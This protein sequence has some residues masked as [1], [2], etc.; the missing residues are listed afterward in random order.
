MQLI[1]RIK[2]SL[3][4]FFV[5]TSQL[6]VAQN[7]CPAIPTN[8][9]WDTNCFIP[10]NFPDPKATDR[11]NG[12]LYL[13]EAT[14]ANKYGQA[15][16][17][18]VI[19]NNRAHWA[20]GIAHAW[21]YSRNINKNPAHPK[22]S[23]WMATALQ[24]SEWRCDQNADWGGGNV[25][26]P[27]GTTW[28]DIWVDGCFQIEG[29]NDGSAYGALIQYYPLRFRAGEHPNLVGNNNFVSSTLVKAYY[30]IFTERIAEYRWG[31]DYIAS[32]ENTCDPFAFEKASASSYNGGIYAFNGG[33]AWFNRSADG[34][35]RW[36]GLPATTAGY[37][38]QIGDIMAV[39]EGGWFNFNGYGITTFNAG[40][41][42]FDGYYNEAITWL[43]VVNYMDDIDDL[44]FDVNFATDVTPNAQAAFVK[45]AG[46][47]ANTINFQDI[48]PVIDAVILSLPREDAMAPALSN[49]GS[50]QGPNGV[51]CSG[52]LVPFS[53]I[54][55]QGLTT[56][57]EGLSLDLF[58]VIDGGGG[59]NPTYRWREGSPSGATIGTEATLTIS[60]T[61]G[62]YTYY[63]EVCN[64]N[65]CYPAC[66]ELEVV[67]E[68]CGGCGMTVSGVPTNTP[69][70]GM[71]NGSIDL[72]INGNASNNYQINYDGQTS[73][74]PISGNT[75]TA[76][77]TA[78][79]TGFADG[80]YN[81]EIVDLTDPTCRAFTNVTVG[82]DT[83]INEYI[84]ASI[85]GQSSSPTCLADLQGE[86]VELP[87]PC[88]FRVEVSP[89]IYGWP[90]PTDTTADNNGW[91]A[92]INAIIDP[93]SAGAQSIS[94][95][96]DRSLPAE[97]FFTM[98]TG[99]HFDF[100]TQAT[101]TPGATQNSNYRFRVYDETNDLVFAGY[102]DAG[103]ATA[104]T[105]Y[106]LGSYEVTCPYNPSDYTYS[107][108]PNLNNIVNTAL[109]TTGETSVSNNTDKTFTVTASNNSNPTCILTDTVTVPQDPSCVSN[110]TPPTSITLTPT[111]ATV[112]EG[113]DQ[114]FSTSVTGTASLDEY[115]YTWY[116]QSNN[117]IA[118]KIGLTNSD[119]NFDRLDLTSVTL[120]QDGTYTLRVEDGNSSDGSCYLE[121]TFNLTVNTQ[122]TPSLVIEAD[123]T[124]I[125]ENGTIDFSIT[126]SD[127]GSSPTYSWNAS[128][129]GNGQSSTD[130]WTGATGFTNGETVELVVTN[131]AGCYDATTITSNPITINIDA[132]PSGYSIT[133]PTSACEGETGLTID[134]ANGNGE[135]TDFTWSFSNAT[136]TSDTTGPNTTQVTVDAENG[137]LTAIAT[138]VNSCGTQANIVENLV[139]NQAP[140]AIIATSGDD[141]EYCADL[142][143]VNLTAQAVAGATYTWTGPITGG[144][145]TLS[146]ATAGSYQVEVTS[147]GCSATS[148]SV[149]VIEH[150]LPTASISGSEEICDDG[151]ESATLSIDLTGTPNWS[152]VL[153]DGST[154]LPAVNS[155]STPYDFTTTLAGAYTATS[156][157][158][159]NCTGTTSG[160]GSISFRTNIDTT[161]FSINCDVNDDVIISFDLTGGITAG[162]DVTGISGNLIGTT[163]TSDPLPELTLHTGSINDGTACHPLSLSVNKSCSCPE[164]VSLSGDTTICDDGSTTPLTLTFSGG[165]TYNYDLLLDGN[166]VQ[167]G[168]TTTGSS[169]T[170]QVNDE[171]IYTITNFIGNCPGSTSGSATIAYHD[172]PTATISG[173][174]EICDDGSEDA[175]LTIDFSGS[176]GFTY[177]ITGDG[178]TGTQSVS[179]HPT[180]QA[181]F[182]TTSNESFTI[183]SLVDGNGCIARPQDLIGTADVTFRDIPDTTQM[184][185]T[186][187]VNDDYQIEL[188]LSGGDPSS[189]SVTGASGTLTDADTWLSDPIDENTASTIT[190]TD[191]FACTPLTLTTQK[192]CSCPSFGII[193]GTNEL[194]INDGTKATIDLSLQ[195]TGPWDVVL[196][197]GT[198]DTTINGINTSNFSFETT[199]A[200]TYSINS[201]TDIACTGGGIG[202]ASVIVHP[203]PIAVLSGG[204]PICVGENAPDITVT[205]TGT[206]PFSLDLDNAGTNNSFNPNT[207]THTINAP[208]IGTH[209]VTALQDGNGCVATDL[210][211][212]IE[213]IGQA[214]PSATLS[215]AT[216][217]ACVGDPAG[218]ISVNLTTTGPSTLSYTDG[219]NTF[220]E[221]VSGN[222][223]DIT[224]LI[225]GNYQLLS[226]NDG[227]EALA[228]DIS[229]ITSVTIHALPT[230]E[231]NPDTGGEI[232]DDGSS[233]A[234]IAITLEGNGPW[235]ITYTDGTTPTTTSVSNSPFRFST[236]SAGSYE[237]TAISDANCSGNPSNEKAIVDLTPIPTTEIIADPQ[238][239]L[240]ATGSITLSANGENIT[241]F[242][243]SDIV[244]TGN[245][246]E[247]SELNQSGIYTIQN[248]GTVCDAE[249]TT[250]NLVEVTVFIL[251]EVDAGE[252]QF[253]F[254]GENAELI[255]SSS[256]GS[257]LWTPNLSLGDATSI[258][259]L[260]SPTEE[261]VYTLTS[262]NGPCTSFD[263]MTVFVQHPVLVPSAFTPNGDGTNE[264]WNIGGIET[265]PN[266]V[267]LIFNRWG[268]EVFKSSG[269][270]EP[271]DGRS[272]NGKPLPVGTYYYLI[273]LNAEV[274]TNGQKA[275]FEG[276][277]TIVR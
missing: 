235:T 185:L 163:W 21:N 205:M 276:T 25:G 80:I 208:A 174:T 243:G 201:I 215:P 274:L 56:F 254:V 110:C 171:G 195:G 203:A 92:W 176:P 266:A 39:L 13:P 26:S 238:I 140:V 212:P 193:S 2:I 113:E 115:Y 27:V 150:E 33:A 38:S 155:A 24:E 66:C 146:N 250:S 93:S 133:M 74:G 77:T 229:D 12:K 265:Y 219:T 199:T 23:Y 60:P 6:V 251:P 269:Y 184:T 178:S 99:D 89:V 188:D 139:L 108:S 112:C 45:I 259:T 196:N 239:E 117:P 237:L 102:S 221:S 252:D 32:V 62:T 70:T 165:T 111:T 272:K 28:Q 53:H 154:D 76:T 44:Y 43:D 135:A 120:S 34:N 257:S 96:F 137:T 214:R 41:S 236:S 226:L 17:K 167:T 216:V 164:E 75:T 31:W 172:F 125:C 161:N 220:N 20:L 248:T 9:K 114:S 90:F 85:L 124:T 275:S 249:L 119:A 183:T 179:N 271:W 270:N 18:C 46:S 151:S 143:G 128:N 97:A 58:A 95:A 258:Q 40:G 144:G 103:S 245:S 244:G 22:P 206:T 118:G 228:A 169:E 11:V 227:C 242:L 55:P 268:N 87:A 71:L 131:I 68:D 148:T 159:A 273:D 145:Q 101:G 233:T 54:E 246:F 147:S 277:V 49:D 231:V 79:I 72:T 192:L 256:I 153:N 241:W 156:I 42:S 170:I 65:G 116:D 47:T 232:C 82:Y 222:S 173:T 162:Y 247:I 149:T 91:E 182:N 127:I 194:C 200:G 263:D 78:T 190:I 67:V 202:T 130:S 19:P 83:Q 16:H 209:S 175:I 240:C 262:T 64:D 260:A 63:L 104:T 98:N 14:I 3:F 59:S 50:P 94:N 198:T 8:A 224:N 217:V 88:T 141:L 191:Q 225:S 121:E 253:I 29:V 106:F 37:A 48:G 160:N 197:N 211:S 5:L 230:G 4:F 264:A 57:C 81:I 7:N 152:I 189:Y 36:A 207:T 177:E 30:D 73:N 105:P 138:P 136:L 267:V 35:C 107:W 15:F 218:P 142:N 213:I 204:G 84:D 223:F 126:S 255:G 180:N 61:Q 69:C 51:N 10:A 168:L 166:P 210:G 52:D 132:L 109:T 1:S 122:T 134:I 187:D 181:P 261:T 186:C 129:L 86:L 158:D 123:Q 157:S 234:D 100:Y